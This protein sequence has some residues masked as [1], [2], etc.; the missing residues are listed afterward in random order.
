LQQRQQ[1]AS[2]SFLSLFRRVLTLERP[3]IHES[4]IIGTQRVLVTAC[5][6]Q[7]SGHKNRAPYAIQEHTIVSIISKPVRDEREIWIGFKGLKF[8]IKYN[9]AG[10]QIYHCTPWLKISL[11]RIIFSLFYKASLGAHPFKWKRNF[12]YMQIKL[13]FIWMVEHQASLGWWG[14]RQLGNGLL[15]NRSEF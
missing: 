6:V 13:I 9:A 4:A 10:V 8:T 5:T 7:S 15:G 12:I 3:H 2:C 1:N 11:F 14:F